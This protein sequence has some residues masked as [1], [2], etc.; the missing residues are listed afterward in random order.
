MN[1]A[2]EPEV[3]SFFLLLH[4][5]CEQIEKNWFDLKVLPAAKE[6]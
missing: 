6:R 4:M 3:A 1:L 2:V 5:L